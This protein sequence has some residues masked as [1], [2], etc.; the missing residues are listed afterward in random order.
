[1][2]KR[3]RLIYGLWQNARNPNNGWCNNVKGEQLQDNV[4]DMK[5][6]EAKV[7][8]GSKTEKKLTMIQGE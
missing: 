8:T 2:A 6:S 5:T 3:D 4:I 1:M 7:K